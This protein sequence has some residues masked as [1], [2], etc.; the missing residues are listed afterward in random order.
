[1]GARA[2]NETSSAWDSFSAS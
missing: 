2:V 1:M